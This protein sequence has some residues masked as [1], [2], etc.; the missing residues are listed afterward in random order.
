MSWG[1][2][3]AQY[4]V[5]IGVINDGGFCS[6]ERHLDPSPPELIV[7]VVLSLEQWEKK[8]GAADQAYQVSSKIQTQ[9][10][11]GVFLMVIVGIIISASTEVTWI[12]PAV[13]FPYFCGIMAYQRRMATLVAATFDNT[14]GFDSVWFNPGRKHVQPSLTICLNPA[15]HRQ[16]LEEFM[17]SQGMLQEQPATVPTLPPPGH[18]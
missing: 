16:R 14:P 11:Q 6:M 8:I 5:T 10:I 2:R 15:M 12:L 17:R 13:L 7:P 3:D 18:M 4:T 1:S 9:L